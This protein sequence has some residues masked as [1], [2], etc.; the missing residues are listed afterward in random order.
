MTPALTFPLPVPPILQTESLGDWLLQAGSPVPVVV[1]GAVHEGYP[2]IQVDWN[3]FAW[4]GSSW[5][6]SARLAT[7]TIPAV[8]T[9]SV[10]TFLR[11][12]FLLCLVGVGAPRTMIYPPSRCYVITLEP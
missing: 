10:N 1:S 6:A 3:F 4:D 11:M 7:P 9:R 12:T 8:A 2:V 5:V